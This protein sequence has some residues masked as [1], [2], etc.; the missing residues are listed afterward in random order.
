[1]SVTSASTF[2]KSTIFQSS[3]LSHIWADSAQGPVKMSLFL[4]GSSAFNP[5]LHVECWAIS[6]PAIIL[7]TWEVI[8]TK[9]CSRLKHSNWLLTGAHWTCALEL[10][11]RPEL[12][13]ISPSSPLC[14][15][16]ELLLLASHL[17]FSQ[18]LFL[19][20]MKLVFMLSKV[21][22]QNVLAFSHKKQIAQYNVPHCQ[23][24]C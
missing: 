10:L 4:L 11:M 19:C 14:L 5:N 8:Y 15:P 17:L 20:V 7:G 16:S 22:M 24:W 23:I 21:I 18:R 13:E 2:H 6:H 1:M 3:P 12:S 9:I